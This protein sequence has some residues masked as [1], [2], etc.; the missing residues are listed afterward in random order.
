VEGFVEHLPDDNRPPGSET[1]GSF[2]GL[3]DAQ[4]IVIVSVDLN[5]PAG[6]ELPLEIVN[7]GMP[8]SAD[9]KQ[10]GTILMARQPPQFN[11]QEARYLQRI[12]EAL[13]LATVGALVIALV[14]GI[15]L[16]R[17][18]TR[19]VQELTRAAYNITQGQLEQQ[20]PVRSKDEIGQLATAFNRMSQEVARVNQLRRQM[21][22][23]VA[24][25]LRTPLTVISGYVE[26]MRDGVLKPT[27][28]RLTI[29]YTEIERLQNLVGDL[30]M[31]SLA[32]AGEL[33]LNL[34]SIDPKNLLDRACSLFRH[35]AEGQGVMILV[36][37]SQALPEIR[38]DE[39][40]MMQ[41]LDN[42]ISNAL[43]YTLPEG[44][45]TL[46]AQL[47]RSNASQEM[48]EIRVRDTGVGIPDDELPLIFNRF[49]RTD[50][51][52]HT[53]TDE[54]GLGLAIVKALVED[55]G[56]SISAES[57]LGE[58]TTISLSFLVDGLDTD[59]K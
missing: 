28:E 32:D 4:G 47:S 45:I 58:G 56:G 46:A 29:I 30:R 23:D 39:A 3:A 17:T 18:L 24:H 52:R 13:V 26:S 9:G 31:L 35:Q 48:L 15:L 50:Q 40:R 54:S 19:P 33:A 57:T 53:E 25:D 37:A 27:P 22:A 42:L 20:V 2:F 14:M 12:N 43:R 59:Q 41:V 1:R 11:P 10:V 21:T 7:S 34:Q 38:V 8:I 16:A 36:D 49:Y 44:Q 5:Y 51:S 6:S 55:Q